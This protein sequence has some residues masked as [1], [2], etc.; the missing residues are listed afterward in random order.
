MPGSSNKKKKTR[1]SRRRHG[2]KSLYEILG[3]SPPRSSPQSSSDEE[4]DFEAAQ[5]T[6]SACTDEKPLSN[7]P[8]DLKDIITNQLLKALRSPAVIQ[9]IVN[10]VYKSVYEKLAGELHA[11]FQLDLQS[12]SSKLHDLDQQIQKL[13]KSIVDIN[14]TLDDQEQYS[15]RSCLRFH[16]VKET[17]SENTDSVIINLVK[18]KLNVVLQP[19]DID[20]SHRITPRNPTEAEP[21]TPRVIIVKFA[22]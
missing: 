8:A 18:E 4:R 20:R 21:A 12:H 13:Q 22:I 2:G 9:E 16:G 1:A 17:S 11:A 15:R 14:N 3:N 5:P 6:G 7:F 10:A 19:S